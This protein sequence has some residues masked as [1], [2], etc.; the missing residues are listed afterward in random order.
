ML[1][2]MG[3]VPAGI[4]V[5]DPRIIK[6]LTFGG[7]C[8]SDMPS[9]RP[10]TTSTGAMAQN[11]RVQPFLFPL[12]PHEWCQP[13][14]LAHFRFVHHLKTSKWRREQ[15]SGQTA[16]TWR[17]SVLEPTHVQVSVVVQKVKKR[18]TAQTLGPCSHM[19]HLNYISWLDTPHSMYVMHAHSQSDE[20]ARLMFE[21]NSEQ[22]TDKSRFVR[23]GVFF[24]YPE[25]KTFYD[26]NEN[27]FY[28]ICTLYISKNLDLDSSSH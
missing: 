2:H 17:T 20:P 10:L 3:T 25:M 18:R 13:R 9:S 27:I 7:S 1:A 11:K 22:E 8:L 21:L 16:H 24:F 5:L 26:R 15:V 14:R 4:T 19:W 23:V 28:F 12:A 6:M